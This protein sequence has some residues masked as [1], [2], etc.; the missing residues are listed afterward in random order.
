MRFFAVLFTM[1]LLS[2]SVSA[3]ALHDRGTPLDKL[4]GRWV[5]SGTIAGQE[6]VHDL[7]AE[8]VPWL[9]GFCDTRTTFVLTKSRWSRR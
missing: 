9:L 7:A 1:L 4:A 5:M 6:I 2:S 8:W 3:Q